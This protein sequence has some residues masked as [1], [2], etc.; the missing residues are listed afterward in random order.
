MKVQMNRAKEFLKGH[1]RWL[2]LEFFIAGFLFDVFTLGRIDSVLTLLQMGAY[3]IVTGVLIIADILNRTKVYE[4]SGQIL[5]YWPWLIPTIHFLLGSLLS[6]YTLFYFKSTS[7][8]TSLFYV[9]G[10]SAILIINEF[11]RFG[12]HGI[13][14]R[15][16]L[17]YL[18]LFSFF[19]NIPR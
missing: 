11:V 9:I 3:L 6:S 16:C 7:V 10:L 18:S 12:S 14:V 15:V 13:T 17:W 2:A 1:N 4:P 5:K 19:M 8:F